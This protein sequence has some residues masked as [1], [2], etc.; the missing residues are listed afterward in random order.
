M[1]KIDSLSA[2]KRR[3]S[4]PQL[5]VVAPSGAGKSTLVH[6]LLNRHLAPSMQIGIGEK[7]QTTL[8]PCQFCF[9]ERIEDDKTFSIRI[10]KKKFEIKEIHMSVL[11][12][13]T[14]LF[15]RNDCDT[16]ETLYALDE[17]VFEQILEPKE[18]NYHLDQINKENISYKELQEALEPI[19]SYITEDD[20]KSKVNQRKNELKSK[21][22]KLAEVREMVFEEMFEKMPTDIKSKYTKWLEKIGEEIEIKL[23]HEIGTELFEG[24]PLQCNLEGD[25]NADSVL[26]TLFDPFAP[27]SLVIDHILM[28]CRPRQELIDIKEKTKSWNNLP[29]RL[30]IRDTMGLTQTGMS[31]AS[32]KNAL[33]AALN[34]KADS[35]LF[36]LPLDQ[37]E[38]TL[39]ECCK[40]LVEKKKELKERR[41]LDISVYVLFTK[42][43]RMV[44]NLINKCG[45]GEL[46]IDEN[47]YRANINE[48]LRNLE[49]KVDSYVETFS[50][51]K[52]KVSWLS[53]RY[54]KDSYLLKVLEGDERKH[55][56]P[57]GLFENIV[58]Y[59][60][61]TFRETSL[62]K[63]ESSQLITVKDFDK[64]AIQVV[65][66]RNKLED[67]IKIIQNELSR[68][69]S[70]VNEYLISDKT[71]RIH[72]RSVVCY[73]RN[74]AIGL[75]YKTNAS[76][77]GNFTINMKGLLIRVLNATLGSFDKLDNAVEFNVDNVD[78]I[79]NLSNNISDLKELCS[80]YFVEESRFAILMDRVA[81]DL[82][83]NN[84]YL[85]ERLTEIYCE[86]PDYDNSM[87]KLQ[88]FFRNFFECSTFPKM[89]VEELSQIMTEMVNKAFIIA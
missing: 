35:I 32:I 75:G 23:K 29:F 55:F 25:N 20:F 22:I 54:L 21:R 80:K 52:K 81:Y 85:K 89:F 26:K 67:Q 28:A 13:L 76:V 68:N 31:A 79:G 2:L 64:S 30:C 59:S 47:I 11:T 16:E 46:Y 17:T 84:P 38:D 6:L 65:V 43:D 86:E 48:V 40:A 37:R 51:E 77:Y 73:W 58:N 49:K 9:D 50:L 66:D 69:P 33:E 7:S 10:I 45:T 4:A 41:N 24:K 3:S 19:L 5:V 53:M 63:D 8:I 74:L 14:D 34:C 42:A 71:P 27:Y 62:V 60:M 44:E 88:K 36:L 56:E 70:I 61:E 39:S 1:G 82:S 72:G 57:D 78:T 87:R 12:V 83:Y 15:V 18:A